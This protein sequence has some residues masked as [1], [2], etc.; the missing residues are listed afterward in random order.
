M[1]M[2]ELTD[3]SGTSIPGSVHP[4][5]LHS[6]WLASFDNIDSPKKPYAQ[7]VTVT[8]GQNQSSATVSGLTLSAGNC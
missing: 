3:A 7:L 4:D 5:P 2:A 1:I 6:T 8:A